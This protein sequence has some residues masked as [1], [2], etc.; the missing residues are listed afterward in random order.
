[1]YMGTLVQTC[2]HMCVPVC[3][4]QRLTLVCS[5]IPFHSVYC[6]RSRVYPDFTDLASLAGH[7]SYLALYMVLGI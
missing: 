4:G 6:G 3:G 7:H 2:M 1:M 5:L